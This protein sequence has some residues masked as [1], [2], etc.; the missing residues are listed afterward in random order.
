VDA[1]GEVRPLTE[2]QTHSRWSNSCLVLVRTIT[3]SQWNQRGNPVCVAAWRR[4]GLNSASREAAD[5]C[6]RGGARHGG[7]EKWR[8]TPPRQRSTNL[9]C[10]AASEEDL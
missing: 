10:P 5:H 7:S 2:S 9:L 8:P 6:A 4:A 1:T 3:E